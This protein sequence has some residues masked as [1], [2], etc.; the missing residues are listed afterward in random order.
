MSLE[1]TVNTWG[2]SL[3]TEFVVPADLAELEAGWATLGS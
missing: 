2:P 3:P 1:H